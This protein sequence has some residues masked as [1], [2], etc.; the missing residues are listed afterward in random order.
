MPVLDVGTGVGYFRCARP[1][2]W[3]LEGRGRLGEEES[4]SNGGRSE[5]AERLVPAMLVVEIDGTMAGSVGSM[6]DC[7]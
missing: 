2:F 4:G 7:F 5:G 3:R 6:E 1:V